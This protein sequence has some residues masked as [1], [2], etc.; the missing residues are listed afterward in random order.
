MVYAITATAREADSNR[1]SSARLSTAKVVA[2][3]HDALQNTEH[4]DANH[5]FSVRARTVKGLCKSRAI[6]A[7]FNH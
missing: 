5:A 4:S 3:R 7:V 6:R 2:K 1:D